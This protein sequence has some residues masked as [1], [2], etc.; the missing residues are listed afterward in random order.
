MKKNII[1]VV[2]VFILFLCTTFTAQSQAF[3][4]IEIVNDTISADQRIPSVEEFIQSA[5][6]N[7]PLLKIPDVEMQQIFE[8]IKIEK[9]KWSDY[10]YVDGIVRYGLNDQ[11]IVNGQTGASTTNYTL[12]SANKQLTYYGGLS[13]KLP[14]SDLLSKKSQLKILNYSLK[15]SKFRKEQT[16]QEITNIVIE[17]Y[18]K[19][20]KLNQI[21]QVY[22]NVMQTLKISYLKAQKD[23][24]NGLMEINDYA[25]IVISKGKAEEGY[26]NAQNDY[27]AQYRKIQVLTG[28]NLNLKK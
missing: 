28:L 20:I 12:N 6:K 22:L 18:Y 21:L 7:S 9:K 10:L 14:L 25:S 16:E 4:S 5:L 27:Y 13:I 11:L 17:E 19:L 24:A 15:E 23:V 3:Q 1:K 2:S 26:Y 8:K